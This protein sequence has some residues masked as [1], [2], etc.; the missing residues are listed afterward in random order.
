MDIMM[1]A[2]KEA[3]FPTDDRRVVCIGHSAGGQ[4]CLNYARYWKA[5]KGVILLDSYPVNILN[6]YTS[7]KQDIDPTIEYQ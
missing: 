2:M 4:L 7:Q 1:K 6:Y 5:I 3:N